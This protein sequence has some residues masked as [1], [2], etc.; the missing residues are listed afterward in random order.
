MLRLFSIPPASSLNLLL[1]WG[2]LLREVRDGQGV[3]LDG[4][5]KTAAVTSAVKKF[6]CHFQKDAEDLEFCSLSG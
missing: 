5:W 1:T 6:P 3:S 2:A 4:H